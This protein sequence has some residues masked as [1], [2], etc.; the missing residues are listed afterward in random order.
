MGTILFFF[1]EAVWGF[2]QAKLMTF[3]SIISIAASLF[4]MSI[5]AVALLNVD[6]I[7]RKGIDQADMAAYIKDETA[8]NDSVT[9]DLLKRVRGQP[10]VR[11]AVLVDKDSAWKRFSSLYGTSMLEAVDDN[12]LPASLEIYLADDARSQETAGKLTDIIGHY[13]EIE[14]VRYSREWIDLVERFRVGFGIIVII[15]AVIMNFILYFMISNTIRLTI[16]ARKEL[17]AH[18][19]V[20]GATALFIKMPFLLEG[21][22]QGIIGGLLC[23]AATGILRLSLA[24]FPI[25]WG[26][27]SLPSWSLPIFIVLV[28]VVY[29]WMGSAGAVRKFLV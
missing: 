13:P 3:V 5:I 11:R 17:I 10:S 18:M 28:G 16:Y 9:A 19:Q 7:L 8:G 6:S 25:A 4:L 26:P 24:H 12:P 22:L 1:K 15:V 23:V 14:S 2:Y 20:V 27:H 21:I 29:G